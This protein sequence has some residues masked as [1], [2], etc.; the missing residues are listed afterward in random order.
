[1]RSGTVQC[2]SGVAVSVQVREV[3]WLKIVKV[4]AQVVFRFLRGLVGGETFSGPS[5]CMALLFH[6]KLQEFELVGR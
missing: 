3:T 4:N 1:M 2:A 6:E 5:L